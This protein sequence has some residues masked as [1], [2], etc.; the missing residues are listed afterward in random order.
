MSLH[1]RERGRSRHCWWPRGHIPVGVPQELEGAQLASAPGGVR[2]SE[3]SALPLL[4]PQR[5]AQGRRGPSDSRSGKRRVWPAGSGLQKELCF[6]GASGE[7]L[8][9]AGPPSPTQRALTGRVRRAGE[10][11]PSLALRSRMGREL[12]GHSEPQGGAG[13][14]SSWPRGP[15]PPGW[16]ERGV[17]ARVPAVP[18]S[19]SPRCCLCA[20]TG[21]PCLQE[22][23]CGFPSPGPTSWG[24]SFLWRV[25]FPATCSS[26]VGHVGSAAGASHSD[27][28]FL[29]VLVSWAPA[30]SQDLGC[31]RTGILD[32]ERSPGLLRDR[33]PRK[34]VGPR[35]AHLCRSGGRS[36]PAAR[37]RT[38][39]SLG[40]SVQSPT[41][42]DGR[43]S[44]QET[45]CFSYRVVRMKM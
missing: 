34:H 33:H 14:V 4:T 40:R 10:P 17:T 1:P 38:C 43:L 31:M 37:L 26:R 21:L 15:P 8:N 23:T 2:L 7:P 12:C 36:V 22:G 39:G 25:R 16:E 3:L 27:Q 11:L 5:P 45:L 44:L 29:T 19:A 9:L 20:G 18:Q 32:A 42:W 13:D 6:S 24:F 35:A 41:L 30:Q 28:G